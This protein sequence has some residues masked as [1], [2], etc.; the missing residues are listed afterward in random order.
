MHEKPYDYG[1]CIHTGLFQ[2]T[3]FLPL[4]ITCHLFKIIFKKLY[5]KYKEK[6][7]M[8]NH[9]IMVYACQYTHRDFDSVCCE[10][11]NYISVC[12]HMERQTHLLLQS[13]KLHHLFFFLGAT[14]PIWALAYL[15]ETLCFISGF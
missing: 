6:L 4:S 13:E 9:M 14:A 12:N 8:K 1:L 15:H 2:D 10:I 11:P 5:S 7:C 3:N